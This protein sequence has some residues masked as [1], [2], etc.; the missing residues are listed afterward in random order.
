MLISLSVPWMRSKILRENEQEERQQL[1]MEKQ[2][3]EK[4]TPNKQKVFIK[5][6]IGNLIINLEKIYD[7]ELY[8]SYKK[9]EENV[10]S[11]LCIISLQRGSQPLIFSSIYVKMLMD[12]IDLSMNELIE[13]NYLMSKRVKFKKECFIQL[14]ERILKSLRTMTN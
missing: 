10:L 4:P 11:S 5:L 14:Y 7:K 2:L 9:F 8:R 3:K 6:I 13:I 12:F 1:M